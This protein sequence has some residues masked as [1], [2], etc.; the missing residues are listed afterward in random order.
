MTWLDSADWME[1]IEYRCQMPAHCTAPAHTSNRGNG[2]RRL[3]MSAV[4]EGMPD[5]LSPDGSS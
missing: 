1:G 3:G 4:G 2:K 5:S